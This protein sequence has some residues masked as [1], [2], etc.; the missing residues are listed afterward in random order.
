[1]ADNDKYR[2]MLEDVDVGCQRYEAPMIYR[3]RRS[4]DDN[5]QISDATPA[6]SIQVGTGFTGEPLICFTDAY[7]IAEKI[8]EMAYRAKR[9][10][11]FSPDSTELWTFDLGGTRFCVAINVEQPLPTQAAE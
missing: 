5:T 9:S 10:N 2:I 11:K 7:S 8:I 3:K 4:Y 1:M 6:L